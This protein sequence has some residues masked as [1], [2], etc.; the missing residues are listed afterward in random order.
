VRY[1]VTIG[2]RVIEVDLTGSTPRVD[3][4][5]VQA[6]LVSLGNGLRHLQADGESVTLAAVPGSRRGEWDL[7]LAGE[8]VRADVVDERTRAIREMTGPEAEST[9]KQVIAPMPGRVLRVQVEVGEP[10]KAGQGVM[11]VEAMK[12]ENELKAP[13]DGVVAGIAVAAGQ[14][15][16]KGAVLLTLE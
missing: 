8:R 2:E 11:I 7:T 4:V 10:V 1:Y 14:T 15:V 5:E 9:V 12:M 16:E 3:G 6:E 13:A